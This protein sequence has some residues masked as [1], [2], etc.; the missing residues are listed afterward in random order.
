MPRYGVG[1]RPRPKAPRSGLPYAVGGKYHVLL[2]EIDAIGLFA[3][4][5]AIQTEELWGEGVR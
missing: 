4:F 2:A 3:I 1:G 5:W